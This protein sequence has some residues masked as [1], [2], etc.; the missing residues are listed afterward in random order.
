M[1]VELLKPNRT[2]GVPVALVA[3]IAVLVSLAAFSGSLAELVRRWTTQEEYSHGFLI[4]IVAAW[5][6]W[7][8]REA[9]LAAIERPSWAGPVLIFLALGMHVI[10]ELSAL[11]IFSQ[12]GFVVTLV[13]IALSVG[14][15][16]LLRA[17]CVPIV[18]LLF[19]IPLP[20]FIDAALTLRL[21]FISSELGTLF[22]RMFQIPVYLE[23]N[24]IDLGYYKLQVVEACSGLR[25]LYPLLSLGFLAAYLF[26]APFWQRAVVFLSTIPITII[27]NGFRIGLVGVTVDRWGIE[28]A[29]EALH[30]FEGWI[31]FLACSGL[32][33]GEIFLLARFSGKRMLEVFDLPNVK[34]S[35]IGGAK[36]ERTTTLLPVLVTLL[37][38]SAGAPAVS[39]IS[40]RSEIVPQR[41]RFA[42]FPSRIG[43]WQGHASL[44]DPTTEQ[45]LGVD[46][47]ILSDYDRSDG[48]PVNLYV[49]YYASQRSGTSPHSP[50]VCIPGEGWLITKLERTR[51]AE[52]RMEVPFNRVVIEKNSV[53]E[54]VY[55]WF[56]ER[57]RKIANEY[58]SKWYLLTD[59][60]IKNR[61]DGS[62]VRL[63]TQISAGESERDA[64]ERLKSFMGDVLPSLTQYLPSGGVGEVRSIASAP[65]GDNL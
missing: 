19:A 15:Y 47:Y 30:F 39:S 9:V 42:S 37:L 32:L 27:M 23:G 51:Y 41:V 10:G 57:G 2:T 20:Y 16:S 13:G 8:Q 35:L 48:K 28:M 55:Y 62:L 49:A 31:I 50:V 7:R 34:A 33:A 3:L 52:L 40:G 54:L 6:L 17:T 24:I 21:Q 56:D 11:F 22:I 60:I 59:A 46:D 5:L 64:D 12:L 58:W 18:F 63:S 1:S 38:L 61:T 53:R 26:Q 65:G 29:D 4:P 14:G 36:T 25:Y 45:G 44:L 43:Q